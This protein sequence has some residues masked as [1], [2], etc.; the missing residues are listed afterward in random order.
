MRYIWLTEVVKLVAMVP[1]EMRNPPTMT[2]SW[3]PKR[4]VNAEDRGPGDQE[5]SGKH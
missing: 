2:T 4:F 5:R 3:N 1:E